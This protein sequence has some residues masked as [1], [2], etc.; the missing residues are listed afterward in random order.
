MKQ[1]ADNDL[2]E[3]QFS[4]LVILASRFS[5]LAFASITETLGL[6]SRAPSPMKVRVDIATSDGRPATA[7]SGMEI[8]ADISLEMHPSVDRSDATIVC[9]GNSLG[10]EESRL[11]L[12]FVR[13]RLR[14]GKMVHV[15][16]GGAISALASAGLADA[17]AAHWDRRMAL[18]ERFPLANVT[19]R[20]YV[21][22]GKIVTCAGEMATL[23]MALD[24]VRQFGGPENADWLGSYLL[25][26]G[27]RSGFQRQPC[28]AADRFRAIPVNLRRAIELIESN[29]EDPVPT[30]EIAKLLGLSRRQVERLFSRHTGLSP[31]A[32]C[33]RARL[34]RSLRLLEQ[35]ELPLTEIALASGFNSASIF[36]RNFRR[37]F[38]MTPSFARHRVMVT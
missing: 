23:D 1:E 21:P 3:E 38:G 17:L 35:T 7:R 8:N 27:P 12:R 32:F 14:D 6:L 16:G 37:E 26:D 18:A 4:V 19:D 28:R 36:A 29:L 34:E 24:L 13:A 25:V 15:L 22:D 5:L 30:Q 11:I 31:K 20:L 33:R 2:S 10:A 9:S